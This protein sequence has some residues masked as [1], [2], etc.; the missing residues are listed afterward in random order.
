M[1]SNQLLLWNVSHLCLFWYLVFCLK[2]RLLV[3]QTPYP[4]N[5]PVQSAST[6]TP[7]ALDCRKGHGDTIWFILTTASSSQ[8]RREKEKALH[9]QMCHE[10]EFTN[11]KHSVTHH[12]QCHGI[13]P[14]LWTPQV[15]LVF[16]LHNTHFHSLC[17]SPATSDLH[18]W[19]L[20]QAKGSSP[21]SYM[22]RRVVG[23]YWVVSATAGHILHPA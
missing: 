1:L 5:H 16:L 14:A 21:R 23:S 13:N 12:E 6:W 4:L 9:L 2:I 8:R 7:W 18:G 15:L 10:A 19:A 20:S 17:T 3:L 22:C 11:V